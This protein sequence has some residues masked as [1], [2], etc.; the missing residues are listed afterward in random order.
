M[1]RATTSNRSNSSDRIMEGQIEDRVR[2]KDT[3]K[4]RHNNNNMPRSS[5]TSSTHRRGM[6]MTM[7]MTMDMDRITLLD[8]RT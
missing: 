4:R 2:H 7:V 8:V 5:N 6:V 3:I 1:T